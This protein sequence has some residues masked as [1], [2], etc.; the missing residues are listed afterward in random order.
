M[1]KILLKTNENKIKQIKKQAETG[2][3]KLNILIE[4]AETVCK[5]TFNKEE[6]DNIRDKGMAF[7]LEYF[8]PNFPFPD[9]D[10]KLNFQTLG[11]DLKPLNE[12]VRYNLP[13][14]RDYPIEQTESGEFE[15]VAEPVQIQKC[16][17]YAET[18]RQVKAYNL[19]VKISDLLNEAIA[20]NYIP[21]REAYKLILFGDILTANTSQNRIIPNGERIAKMK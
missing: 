19:G 12:Y 16:Y 11:I 2:V 17:T 6:R 8:K 14:W 5:T 9:A 7:I 1:S 21:E 18:E 13:I 15:L 4:K 10:D 3:K 20:E